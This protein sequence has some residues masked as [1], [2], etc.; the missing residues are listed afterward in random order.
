MRM[1]VRS[2]LIADSVFRVTQ[3]DFAG[4]GGHLGIHSRYLFAVSG[5]PF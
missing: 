1:R 3:Q 5:E 4:G 2:V